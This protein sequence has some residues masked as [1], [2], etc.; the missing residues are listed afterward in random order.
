MLNNEYPPLGG[1]MGMVNYALLKQFANEPVHDLD[2]ITAS[3]TSRYTEEN[4][5][6]Q[7]KI[8]RLP[9]GVKNPHH[10][11]NRD[12]IKYFVNALWFSAIG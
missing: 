8:F 3:A 5:G 6:D 4:I 11:T 2:L 1:G 7:I 9:I 10:A 12:L